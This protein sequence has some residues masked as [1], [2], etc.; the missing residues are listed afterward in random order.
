MKIRQIN[1]MKCIQ[2]LDLNP[3]PR[4][5][6]QNPGYE[7]DQDICIRLQEGALGRNRHLQ[8]ALDGV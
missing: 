4:P 5:F 7:P 2:I 3:K 8:D 1:Q 6:Q